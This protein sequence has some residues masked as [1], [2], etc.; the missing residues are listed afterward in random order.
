MATIA[1]NLQAII[2]AKADIKAALIEQGQTPTD[3]FS[4]YGNLVRAIESGGGTYVPNNK[5]IFSPKEYISITK[6][7]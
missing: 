6:V 5:E 2:D 1:E 4:A 7:E 3:E